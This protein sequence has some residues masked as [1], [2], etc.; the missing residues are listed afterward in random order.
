M[1][2]CEGFGYRNGTQNQSYLAGSL[3]YFTNL[4]NTYKNAIWFSGHSH[5][6]F[7]V[8][9]NYPNVNAYNKN[10]EICT[11]IHVPTLQE[12]EYYIATVYDHLVELEGYKNG[13]VVNDIYFAIDDYIYTSPVQSVVLDKSTLNF[14]NTDTQTII[15]T[16]TPA[17]QQNL[18]TW[19]TSDPSVATVTNGLVTVTAAS[20]GSCTITAKCNGHSAQCNVTVEIIQKEVAFSLPSKTITID[21]VSGSVNLVDGS[22]LVFEKPLRANTRYY[23]RAQSLKYEDGTD[24]NIPVDKI[25][26]V[27][28]PYV[29]GATT[30]ACGKINRDYSD[31]VNKDVVL[32]NGFGTD[33]Q[34]LIN[35]DHDITKFGNIAKISGFRIKASSKSPVTFPK[36][37]TLTGFE[38]FTYGE[39]F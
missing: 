28:E 12:G 7:E 35:H 18:V 38:I 32:T 36:T 25:Y 8:Q 11:M 29:V 17:S 37:I 19:E 6:K 13:E 2:D 22:I 30:Q 23:M 15:A 14:A 5:T 1:P 21:R 20:S 9:A 26:I 39:T 27:G 4:I 10:G 33:A 3:P 16:V 34:D 31:F 24:V